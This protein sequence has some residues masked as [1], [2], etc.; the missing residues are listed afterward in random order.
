M[1]TTTKRD[2][3]TLVELA[4]VIV[5]IGFLVAGIA[6][7]SNMIKQAE[8]RSMISDLQSYQTAYN[9]FVGRYNKVPGDMDVA[10]SYWS[11]CATTTNTNCDGDGDGIIEHAATVAANETKQAWRQLSLAGMI[12][13]GIQEVATA[14]DGNLVLGTEAPSSKKAGVGFMMA[15]GGSPASFGA[16]GALAASDFAASTNVVFIGSQVTDLGLSGGGLTPEEAFNIDQKLDDGLV[17]GGNFQGAATGVV[18]T[19]DD[20]LVATAGD[21]SATTSNNYTIATTT[22]D[23]V[24]GLALN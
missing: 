17:A 13:A 23:C 15:S 21:C 12:G 14:D 4:I 22:A 6:A 3:F 10:S 16:T 19:I 5:I 8:L 20:N 1:T 9:N 18:R 11:N 2:G 24:L 7:G